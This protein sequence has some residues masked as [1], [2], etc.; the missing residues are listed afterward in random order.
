MEGE[1]YRKRILRIVF[2][3][4]LLVL[5]PIVL[6]LGKAKT[7]RPMKLTVSEWSHRLAKLRNELIA[8]DGHMEKSSLITLG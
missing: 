3:V 5:L 7:D 6:Y 8:K 4:L 1:E 2:W